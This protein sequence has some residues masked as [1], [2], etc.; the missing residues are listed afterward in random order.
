MMHPT[1]QQHTPHFVRGVAGQYSI[2]G[3]YHQKQHAVPVPTTTLSQVSA[4]QIS[5]VSP[6]MIHRAAR[7]PSAPLQ[8]YAPVMPK[9]ARPAGSTLSSTSHAATSSG[10][11]TLPRKTGDHAEIASPQFFSVSRFQFRQGDAVEVLW[12]TS[13]NW[14]PATISRD[15]GDGT[16]LLDWPDGSA[17]GRTK[18]LADVRPRGGHACCSSSHQSTEGMANLSQAPNVSP[19]SVPAP[20]SV[21]VPS[22]VPAISFAP[23]PSASEQVEV[24]QA[25]QGDS[26]SRAERED[27]KVFLQE[28]AN[29]EKSVMVQRSD[30]KKWRFLQRESI[31]FELSCSAEALKSWLDGMREEQLPGLLTLLANEVSERGANLKSTEKDRDALRG[32]EDYDFFGLDGQECT[33]KDIERA[34][35]K[36]STQLH[37]DK[38]GDEA[39]FNQMR[40]KYDQL[41]SLRN[42]NKRKEGGG[43]IK[44]DPRNRDSM[45]KAH[46]ELRDQLVWITKAHAKVKDEI[47]ELELRNAARHQLTWSS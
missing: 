44:W 25:S 15:N 36:K 7:P 9:P 42:E 11:K 4:Q 22:S 34:Y 14:F 29:G 33:D 3:A 20:S 26:E 2:S 43:S 19:S 38:G 8:G 40:E 28:L 18:K 17:R 12:G 41:K 45:M 6:Q 39:S 16:V 32:E 5:P 24:T 30:G 10:S 47:A 27:V 35:R 13:D 46:T 37:P 1:M 21:P 31:E 23:A